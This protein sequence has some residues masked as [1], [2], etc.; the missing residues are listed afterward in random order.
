MNK[1]L[2]AI[3]L[4]TLISCN[5]NNH[6]VE[7]EGKKNKATIVQSKTIDINAFKQKTT[8]TPKKEDISPEGFN[9]IHYDFAQF[10][11]GAFYE[12]NF[13][14]KYR[15]EELV[16]KQPQLTSYLESLAKI[17]KNN[18]N[19]WEEKHRIP[20]LIN[21]YHASLI[22]LMINKNFKNLSED[23]YLVA[24]TVKAFGRSYSLKQFIKDEI[25][26]ATTDYKVAFTLKCFEN[27]CP[28][29]RNTIYNYKNY[30]SLIKTSTMRYFLDDKK[31]WNKKG[32]VIFPPLMRQFLTIMPNT[33][34]ELKKDLQ[35][36]ANESPQNLEKITQINEKL[37]L[38]P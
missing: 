36:L 13:E 30:D 33:Q 21:T 7:Q 22:N 6:F 15:E 17:H 20:F 2:S 9:W 14:G 1:F 31:S 16:K 34:S 26:P 12:H 19:R 28:E 8:Y 10:F 38:D 24:D 5:K 37:P 18:F 27:N 23:C 29:F 32:R 25:I 11:S 35:K 4:A 3:I